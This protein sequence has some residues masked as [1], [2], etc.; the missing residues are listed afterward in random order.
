MS[1]VTVDASV[2]VAAA[3]A[4]DAF[5]EQ[6][7][8]FLVGAHQRSARL[9]IPAF[10][11]AEVACA[12]ARKHRNAFLARGLTG[13]VLAPGQIVHVPADTRLLAVTLRLGTDAFLR[14]ADALYAATAQ[15][16][17]A[18]LVSWDNELIQRAG[19]ITPTAWLAANP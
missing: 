19:A 18:A 15:L 1:A 10:T 11:V 7:R 4:S 17:G 9:V 5:C 8:A 2:W 14:G 6:S 13:S 16:A 12:L 3:D